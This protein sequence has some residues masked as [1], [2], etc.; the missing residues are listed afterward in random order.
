MGRLSK[1]A[2]AF[3]AAALLI[4]G[5]AYAF[6]SSAVST[7]TV[8]VS[9][10]DGT[11]YKAKKCASHDTNLTWNRRGPAGT[12]G[13]TGAT[14]PRGAPGSAVAYAEV[15]SHAVLNKARSKNVL[16]ITRA[17]AAGL[18]AN[19]A[20]KV[21][22][23]ICFDLGARVVNAV[24]SYDGDQPGNPG[25]TG[26]TLDPS[27]APGESP[28]CPAGYTDA[29]VHASGADMGGAVVGGFFVAFN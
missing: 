8:C 29:Q 3:G 1:S 6:A 9:H 11:L 27:T 19:C 10:T 21:N 14:G 25:Y 17:C 28:W 24:V 26:V 2:A 22:D 12:R 20:S 4:A 23:I 18:N 15:S 7:I 5:G 13:A 16:G